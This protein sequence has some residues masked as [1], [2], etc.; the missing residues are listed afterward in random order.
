MTSCGVVGL[1]RSE[2][3]V[4]KCGEALRSSLPQIRSSTRTNDP[5][6]F[7]H[8]P[9]EY[10]IVSSQPP[11]GYYVDGVTECSVS[12]ASA[13]FT[14]YLRVS[15]LDAPTTPSWRHIWSST[16]TKRPSLDHTR[17]CQPSPNQLSN[18]NLQQGSPPSTHRLRTPTTPTISTLHLANLR[19][20]PRPF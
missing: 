19:R 16:H 4:N 13:G 20:P 15:N 8:P 9:T 1:Q 10:L 2:C 5:T 14:E 12:R 18:F 7:D 11:T 17:N 6:S 3:S